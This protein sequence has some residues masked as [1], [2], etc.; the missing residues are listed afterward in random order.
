MRDS[1]NQFVERHATGWELS[2]AALAVAYVAIGF[3]QDTSATSPAALQIA[4]GVLTWVFVAEFT[5]R[6][7]ASHQRGRYLRDHVLDLVAL[8][9]IARGV[10]IFRLLRLLRL[11]RAFTGFHRAFRNVE[12]VA[13][14]HGLGSLVIAWFGTMLLC[15]WAFLLAESESNALVNDP[16]DAVWWGLM[17]LTGGPATIQAITP[18][19]QFITAILLI[20]GVGLFTAITAVLVSF[21]VA[22]DRK[23]GLV[24]DLQNIEAARAEG[25]L[26]QAEF[27]QAKASI[28]SRFDR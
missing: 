15:S 20:V 14:H 19:G 12:R 4:E 26:S 3:A 10:R 24:N 2:M 17:T 11:V 21:L 8:I 13:N 23:P 28:L 1:F 7:A 5:F 27:E 6:I 25:L 16:G 22:T 18:E 9:P